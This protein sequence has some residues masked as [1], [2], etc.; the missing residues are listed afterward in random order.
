MVDEGLAELGAGHF[1]GAREE[2][3]QVVGGDAVLEGPG[4]ALV[5]MLGR[6]VP[7]EIF[8]QHGAGEDQGTGVDLIQ[9]GIFGG[10]AVGGFEDGAIVADIGP[11]GHPQSPYL[12]RQG[13]GDIVPVQVGGGD[14]LV[15]LRPEQDLLKQVIGQAVLEHRFAGRELPLV[16]R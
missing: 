4:Q 5:D 12:G 2:P 16:D 6:F 14:N 7:A 9:A 10:A 11:R 8:Q 15:F 1:P 13:V 3:G